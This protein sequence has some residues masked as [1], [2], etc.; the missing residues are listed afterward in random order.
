LTFVL[1][2]AFTSVCSFNGGLSTDAI[3]EQTVDSGVTV[4]SVLMKDN[5]VTC[6]TMY[7]DSI[8]EKT[9]SNGVQI[10]NFVNM[11]SAGMSATGT[12]AV[13]SSYVKVTFQSEDFDTSPSSNM[14]N[15][16]SNRIDI[17]KTG[18]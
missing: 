10:D 18:T 1:L 11:Y 9:A 16:S 3:S 12:Q 8:D 6:A 5:A 4:D 7:V 15:L 2:S 14:V 17:Q 13:S